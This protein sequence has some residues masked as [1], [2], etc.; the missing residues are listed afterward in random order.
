MRL[1]FRSTPGEQVLLGLSLLLFGLVLGPFLLGRQLLF[2]KRLDGLIGGFAE[3]G[4]LAVSPVFRFIGTAFFG[5][6]ALYGGTLLLVYVLVKV[7]L[8]RRPW[9]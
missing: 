6:S 9:P 2:V 3:R 4:N 7:K 5:I 1:F 8:I